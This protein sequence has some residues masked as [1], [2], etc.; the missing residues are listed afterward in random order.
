MIG[1]QKE[2]EFDKNIIIYFHDAKIQK[3]FGITKFN[4]LKMV[5]P[6]CFVPL[7][8]NVLKGLD[9]VFPTKNAI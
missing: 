5:I 2:S 1:L 6:Y 3:M 4:V 7:K 9:Y 8:K